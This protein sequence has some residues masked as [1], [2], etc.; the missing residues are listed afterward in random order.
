MAGTFGHL[1]LDFI[2]IVGDGFEMA[3]QAFTL[4]HA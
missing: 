3:M 4:R 1:V 2:F